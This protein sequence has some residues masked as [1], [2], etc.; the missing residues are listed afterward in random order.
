MLFA[1]LHFAF[2]SSFV[3][4]FELALRN[5]LSLNFSYTA[6]DIMNTR[7]S[8]VYPNTSIRSLIN[9]LSTTAHNAFPVVTKSVSHSFNKTIT[10]SQ[11]GTVASANLRYRVNFSHN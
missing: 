5:N 2:Y 10:S 9:L 4:A 3:K 8:F 7:L 6:A 11:N 1:H